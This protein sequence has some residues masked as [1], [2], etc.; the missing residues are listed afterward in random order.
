MVNDARWKLKRRI[1]E[2]YN[3][4]M[5]KQEST[6]I[7]SIK[8]R[9]CPNCFTNILNRNLIKALL[10]FILGSTSFITTAQ[11]STISV[12]TFNVRYDNPDD[13][14]NNWHYRKQ[15]I[16]AFIEHEH[17]D[18]LGIQEGLFHQVT[19]LDS[20]LT[21]YQYVGVGRDDGKTAGEFSPIFYDT[22]KVRLLQQGT[23]WLSL[24]PDTPSVGWDAALPRICTYAQFRSI[25]TSDTFWVYN[26]HFDHVGELARKLSAALLYI[27]SRELHV[28]EL[29]QPIIIMG[30]MNSKPDDVPY[31]LI[32]H[33]FADTRKTS[34]HKPGG[35]EATFN[36]FSRITTESPRIDYIF[37]HQCITI[38]QQHLPATT[39]N[40]LWLSDHFPVSATIQLK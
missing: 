8:V 25:A 19:Y 4:Q 24:T 34:L 30:D 28:P 32:A 6:K 20:A 14:E 38:D 16:V 39:A 37:V 11:D 9:L 26:T 40:G 23:F 27:K 17:P 31:T 5:H 3:Q 36:G 21:S 12:I 13:A 18:I 1:S 15:D 10:L 29:S 7:K 2:T 33:F 35:P 22:T